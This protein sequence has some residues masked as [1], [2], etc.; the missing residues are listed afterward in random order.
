ML[1][2]EG[3]I[4]DLKN[5]KLLAAKSWSQFS[6]DLTTENWEILQQS[7]QRDDTYLNLLQQSY[8]LVC[9]NDQKQIIAMGF[10]VPHGNPTEIYDTNWC[11]LRFVTVDPDYNGLGL[12]RII[13]EKCIAYA[14]ASGEKII[15][16]HTSE[17]M[18]KARHIYERLGFKILRELKPRLGKRYWL[19]I[20]EL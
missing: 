8:C 4:N 3:D 14:K 15:A 11:Y 18:V 9:E 5:L 17:M 20:R 2:R 7:L 13:T 6:K 10:L 1:F 16:L 12:G 19:Y